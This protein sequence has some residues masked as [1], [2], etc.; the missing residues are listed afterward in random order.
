MDVEK[1]E[2]FNALVG[3]DASF[4]SVFEKLLPNRTIPCV[5]WCISVTYSDWVNCISSLAQNYAFIS[6][7]LQAVTARLEKN[8]NKHGL[9]MHPSCRR[10]TAN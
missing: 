6:E 1:R 2:M 10:A 8:W 3:G 5:S 4:A 7:V 9:Y